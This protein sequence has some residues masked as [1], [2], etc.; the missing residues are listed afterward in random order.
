MTTTGHL[1]NSGSLWTSFSKNPVFSFFQAGGT[2][3]DMMFMLASYLLVSKI[4]QNFSTANKIE[5]SLYE[6]IVSRGLRLLVPIVFVSLV[7]VAIGDTWDIDKEKEDYKPVWQ[8]LG[9]LFLLVNNYLPADVYGSFTVSICWSCCVDFHCGIAVMLIA[10]VVAYLLNLFT[11]EYGVN[12]NM[13]F[14]YT[15]RH[16]FFFLL[17]WS[18]YIRGHLFEVDSLNLFKLGKYFHFASV[19]TD[20]SYRWIQQT[21]GHNFAA[22]NDPEVVSYSMNYVNNMYSPTH[23]RFGPYCIGALLATNVYLVTQGGMYTAVKDYSTLPYL[24][25]VVIDV[26]FTLVALAVIIV[27]CLPAEDSAPFEAQLIATAALRTMVSAAASYLLYRFLVPTDHISKIS[28][29]DFDVKE[30]GKNEENGWR[31]YAIVCVDQLSKITY[32]SYLIHF[33]LMLE[34]TFRPSWR[35]MVLLGEDDPTTSAGWIRYLFLLLSAV[36]LICF[37]LSHMCHT[38]IEVPV[39]RALTQ[40]LVPQTD[41]DISRPSKKES[42]KSK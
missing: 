38:Y 30:K 34:M 22:V 15:L 1:P 19:N 27:P 37:P 16:I 13:R 5:T 21:Y 40:L 11:T 14:A 17:V 2:Q 26:L 33:R 6:F 4:L 23:T 32:F 24:F 12:R 39:T 36:I 42:K 20:N 3:V 7:G 25:N 41:G 9:F 10:K 31:A 8:R 29:F 18:V 28:W 35:R